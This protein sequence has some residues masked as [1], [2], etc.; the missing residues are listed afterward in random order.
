MENMHTDVKLERV[1][2]QVQK[3]ITYGVAL[4]TTRQ[5]FIRSRDV[6]SISK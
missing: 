5:A 2:P 3:R 1:K 6:H 4:N